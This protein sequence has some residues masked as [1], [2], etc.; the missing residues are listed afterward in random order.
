MKKKI[1]LKVFILFLIGILFFGF[2]IGSI[3]ASR[4]VGFNQLTY[5]GNFFLNISQNLSILTNNIQ[6]M[7]ITQGG[8]IGISSLN[9]AY[10]LEIGN[11]AN[12][13]NVSSVLYVNGTSGFVG[14]GT[15][16]PTNL[17][18]VAGSLM[19]Y[20]SIKQGSNQSIINRIINSGNKQIFTS[21]GDGLSQGA[22]PMNTFVNPV[23]TNFSEDYGNVDP[24]LGGVFD[25]QNIWLVPFQ[26]SYLVKVNPATGQMT[27][28]SQGYG[29]NGVFNGAVFDGQN[30]WLI[31]Q[32]SSYLVKVNS[33]GGMTNYSVGYGSNAFRGGVFDGQNIWL[34]PYYSS[35][36]VKVN[37]TGGMTNYSQG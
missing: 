8:N 15:S 19:V 30:I 33:T 13:L 36:L 31:P 10:L 29:T 21:I 20:N 37:S 35:Y 9:P 23:M 18:D 28:Y 25:G 26:S 6:S 12:A 17:L 11:S 32:S 2:V 14:I 5:S 7:F 27:N 22:V 4:I 34:V 3:N 1:Y 24:F 16:T